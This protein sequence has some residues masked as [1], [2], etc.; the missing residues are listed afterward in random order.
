MDKVL[1]FWCVMEQE[2]HPFYD[3]IA[4]DINADRKVHSAVAQ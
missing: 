1:I 4:R 3:V 2:H